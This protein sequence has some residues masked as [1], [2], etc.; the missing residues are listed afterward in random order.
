LVRGARVIR[1]ALWF[2]AVSHFVLQLTRSKRFAELP[3]SV[4]VAQLVPILVVAALFLAIRLPDN[5]ALPFTPMNASQASDLVGVVGA[6]LACLAA[7]HFHP[8]GNLL[9]FLQVAVTFLVSRHLLGGW[10]RGVWWTS[11]AAYAYA[12]PNLADAIWLLGL[13]AAVALAFALL[14]AVTRSPL[15]QRLAVEAVAPIVASLGVFAAALYAVGLPFGVAI[16][17]LTTLV[18]TPVALARRWGRPAG[19]VARC[20]RVVALSSAAAGAAAL[21]GVAFLLWA[22]VSGYINRALLDEGVLGY[23][24]TA[25]ATLPPVTIADG[26]R[27]A[28]A[29]SPFMEFAGDERWGPSKVQPFL[30]D[31][32][33]VEPDGTTEPASAILDETSRASGACRTA[34]QCKVVLADCDAQEQPGTCSSADCHAATCVRPCKLWSLPCAAPVRAERADPVLYAHVVRNPLGAAGVAAADQARLPDLLRD[35]SVVVQYWAFYRYDD[36]H[37][38]PF[39]EFRQWH[40]GD[41]ESVTIGFSAH[42]P[43][44]AAFSSHC[45]GTWVPWPNVDTVR[46]V[47]DAKG[48]LQLAPDDAALGETSHLVVYV[49][50]GSHAMYPISTP[51]APDWATCKKKWNALTWVATWGP[52]QSLAVTETMPGP[53]SNMPLGPRPIVVSDTTPWLKYRGWWSSGDHMTILPRIPKGQKDCSA[54]CTGGPDA[55][56]AKPEWHDP[57][58]VIFCGPRWRPQSYA[59]ALRSLV[60]GAAGT[61]QPVSKQG[62]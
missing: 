21:V 57:L 34:R 55:P 17:V 29:Y 22:S 43:L 14:V 49:G 56:S 8:T 59:R 5:I 24:T 51:R 38:W 27:L 62:G 9:F 47:S 2:G 50:R 12:L 60:T 30:K 26:Q 42:E 45:G 32:F 16:V 41:W 19:W 25:D 3:T 33:V 31:A 54:A 46:T 48:H 6:T 15:I 4:H 1:N 10:R 53:D 40:D 23:A 36:W 44:F 20:A 61:C 28:A 11:A 13:G 35:T 18:V 37:A 52:S 58:G 39:D 7:R